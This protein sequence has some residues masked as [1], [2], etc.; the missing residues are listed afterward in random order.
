MSFSARQE[1]LLN[2]YKGNLFEFLVC[3]QLA[4]KS[5]LESKFLSELSKSFLLMLKQQESFIR[6]FYPDLLSKLPLLAKSLSEEILKTL[7]LTSISNIR[8]VGKTAA[9]DTE[10]DYGEAD[11]LIVS[12]D[13]TYPVSIKLNKHKAATNTKSAGVKSF[14]SKYFYDADSLQ[15]NV[16]KEFDKIFDEF[17]FAIHEENGLEWDR[18]FNEWCMR[19]LPGL[20]GELTGS[21]REEY[22][23]FL[24]KSSKLFYDAVVELSNSKNFIKS[25]FS[26]IGFS[27]SSVIQATCYHRDNYDQG[28]YQVFSSK[29][30]LENDFEIINSDSTS[31]FEIKFK[32]ICLIIRIKAMNRFINKSFKVNCSVRYL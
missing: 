22:L 27:K 5:D 3:V 19:G 16:S 31:Y 26:L 24:H 32:N 28:E 7:N 2:E 20:P 1:A 21:S 13:Q 30:I 9:S 11:I 25:I 14:L 18:N 12:L 4:K 10:G 17:S 6:S 23:K 8:L 15:S 29:G